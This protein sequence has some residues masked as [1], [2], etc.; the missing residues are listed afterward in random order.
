MITAAWQ[1]ITDDLDY[2]D[3]GSNFFTERLDRQRHTRHL[4]NQLQQLGYRV[5]LDAPTALG[6]G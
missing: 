1:M 5:Q 2:Q 3:L 6:T 4:V